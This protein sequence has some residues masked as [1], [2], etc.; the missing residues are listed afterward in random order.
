MTA[1]LTNYDGNTVLISQFEIISSENIISEN[2]GQVIRLIKTDG[3]KEKI[4]GKK[5]YSSTDNDGK[6]YT[7]FGKF[8]DL[9]DY[10][11]VEIEG[12]EY[13]K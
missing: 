11:G 13:L 10:K 8:I 4:D 7:V 9:D 3:K 12:V 6:C 5:I 1:T 2:G